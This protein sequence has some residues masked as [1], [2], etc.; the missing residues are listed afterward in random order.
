MP[1]QR[2][3]IID[4]PDKP[5]LQWS[6]TKPG[7]Q[8]VHF[9]VDGD[10][11]DAQIDRMDEEADGFTFKLLGRLTSGQDNGAAFRGVYSV[12]TRSGWIEFNRGT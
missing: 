11:Y 3:T 6:L 4:G 8:N 5:A 9:R 7:E 1:K 12:E 2:V 10:A